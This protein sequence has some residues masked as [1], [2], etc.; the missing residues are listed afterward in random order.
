MRAVLAAI[1]VAAWAAIPAHAFTGRVVGIADGDT[2]TI[3][4][5]Q[6]SV[7]VRLFAIDAPEHGQPFASRA[8]ESLSELA[9]GKVADV[10]LRGRDSYGRVLGRVRVAGLDLNAEQVRRGYAWVFR[11]YSRDAALLALEDDARAARRGLWQDAAP[12]PPWTWRTDHPNSG[13]P[14]APAAAIAP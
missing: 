4:S 2:L 12:V 7:R 11:R 6:R 9:F 14:G 10:D 13:R 5:G 8:R 1:A 3:M